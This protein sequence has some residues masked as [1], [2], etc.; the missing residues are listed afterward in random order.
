MV[1]RVVKQ[2]VA[3]A[4]DYL[5]CSS[6]FLISLMKRN[7]YCPRDPSYPRSTIIQYACFSPSEGLRAIAE[8]KLSVLCELGKAVGRTV[9]GGG[10]VGALRSKVEMPKTNA[11]P[12]HRDGVIEM[13]CNAVVFYGSLVDGWGHSKGP[14]RRMA[15]VYCIGYRALNHRTRVQRLLFS[16]P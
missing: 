15:H 8:M 13:F 9:N 12:T 4:T 14:T 5:R 6:R 3:R 7:S 10:K 1:I 16:L 2:P 11:A